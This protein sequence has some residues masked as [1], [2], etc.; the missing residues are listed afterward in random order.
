MS[1]ASTFPR[2][3]HGYI[4]EKTASWKRDLDGIARQIDRF[5]ETGSDIAYNDLLDMLNLSALRR[6][7]EYIQQRKWAAE[8]K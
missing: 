4:T 2:V 6:E 3:E 7:L 5:A 1:I 8:E